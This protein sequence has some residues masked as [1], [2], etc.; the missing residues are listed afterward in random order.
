MIV[1]VLW[2]AKF[3][4]LHVWFTAHLILESYNYEIDAACVMWLDDRSLST[5][6]VKNGCP[7]EI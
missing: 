1:Y 5:A 2:S 7:F 3:L 4:I 6:C